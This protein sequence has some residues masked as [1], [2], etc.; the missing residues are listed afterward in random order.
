[1]NKPVLLDTGV[2]VALLDKSERYHS[3]CVKALEAMIRPMITC[4]A[5]LAEACYLARQMPSAVNAILKN[6]QSGIIRLPWSL[7]GRED[8]VSNLIDKYSEVPMDFADACLVCMAEEFGTGDILT[9]DSDF[10]VYRWATR[11]TFQ[12]MVDV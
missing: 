6:V 3:S 5:V 12:M 11:K 9:L 2:I 7:I 4:E 8:K 10:K 1:M